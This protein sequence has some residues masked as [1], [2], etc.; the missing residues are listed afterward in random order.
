[1]YKPD[2]NKIREFEYSLDREK[3]KD[4]FAAAGINPDFEKN[5]CPVCGKYSLEVRRVK[6]GDSEIYQWSCG[7]CLN[8]GGVYDLL[9]ALKGDIHKR[10]VDFG[11]MVDLTDYME[12]RFDSDIKYFAKY[13]DRKTGFSNLDEYLT[14]YPGL[15]VIGGAASVGKTTFVVNVCD[16]LARKGEHVVYFSLEQDSMEIVTKLIARRVFEADPETSIDNIQVKNGSREPAVME[17]RSRVQK[18]LKTFRVFAGNFCITVNDIM[19]QVNAYM[20]ECKARPIVVVDYLQL[21]APTQEMIS[22][23]A[24]TKEI[25]DENIKALKKWQKENELLLILI[26]SFNRSNYNEP[27]SYAAFKESG[28]IE[29]T[30]DYL[31]GLQLSVLENP[32]YYIAKG[33]NRKTTDKER[34]DMITK[35]QKENPKQVEVKFLKNRNGKQ[36]F[37]TFFYYHNRNDVFRVSADDPRGYSMNYDGSREEEDPF[38]TDID[39]DYI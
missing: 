16:N 30:A 29:Y 1:M 23:H 10:S 8:Y 35:A 37:E 7:N 25:I 13:K 14:L 5:P 9:A 18:E 12:R 17:A 22:R 34:Y 21:I 31:L 20:D 36:S 6:Q 33:T 27:V 4:L 11:K 38:E 26:S 19:N 28:A 3:I 2:M 39:D 32:D 15:M 24:Q